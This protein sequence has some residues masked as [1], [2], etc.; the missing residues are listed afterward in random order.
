M[1]L[2]STRGSWHHYK[3]KINVWCDFNLRCFQP[4]LY[5]RRL[6]R[7]KSVTCTRM[8]SSRMRTA[9]TLTVSPSTLCS[10][11]LC[12]VLGGCTWSGGWC[13]VQ[14][15]VCSGGGAWSQGGAP[16]PGGVCLVWGGC[17]WSG[18]PPLVD[19]MTHASENITL[20]QTSFAG[21]NN[22]MPPILYRST[23]TV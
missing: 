7:S 21:G 2:R 22:T 20:P 1:F 19:R 12:L 17:T 8:H 3:N 13:L 11:G 18:T 23:T 9:R 4:R 15:G 16:G 10:G 6:K 5:F 14:G